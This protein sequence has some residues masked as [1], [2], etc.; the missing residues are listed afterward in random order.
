[1]GLLR[2]SSRRKARQ[3]NGRK[4]ERKNEEVRAAEQKVPRQC[5]PFLEQ[6]KKQSACWYPNKQ[7]L[8]ESASDSPSGTYATSQD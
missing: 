6:G 5:R 4:E 7:A 2:T 3:N 8:H 1:M